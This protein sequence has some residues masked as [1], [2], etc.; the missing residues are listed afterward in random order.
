LSGISLGL[1][2]ELCSRTTRVQPIAAD[3]EAH[4]VG[5]VVK[6]TSGLDD[7]ANRVALSSKTIPKNTNKVTSRQ[8]PHFYAAFLP[9]VSS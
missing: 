7:F 1:V 6:A 3:Q 2:Q 8:N 4:S 5:N 9:V